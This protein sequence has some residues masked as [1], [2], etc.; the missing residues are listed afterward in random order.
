M[1]EMIRNTPP[2]NKSRWHS[3]RSLYWLWYS[4][5][6][7]GVCVCMWVCVCVCVCNIYKA[8]SPTARDAAT[9]V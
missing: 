9:S 5:M 3:L 6:C 1:E 2:E 7:V 4:Y 8:E